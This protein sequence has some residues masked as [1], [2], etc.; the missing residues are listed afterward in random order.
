MVSKL[1]WKAS[2]AVIMISLYIIGFGLGKNIKKREEDKVV[3]HNIAEYISK[4][5]RPG[6]GFI[7]IL[8]GDSS[9]MKLVPFYVNLH[10]PI[11]FCP[12]YDAPNIKNNEG[13]IQYAEVKNVKY[14]LWDEKNWSKTQV[15]IR[16]DEFRQTFNYLE[17]WYNQEYGEIIL[18]RRK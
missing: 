12:V 1:G 13:L 3:Y 8:T 4:Q 11:G 17:R 10:L 6:F 14:F 2:V 9:S 18:F 7:S 16:S 15:D 5:E